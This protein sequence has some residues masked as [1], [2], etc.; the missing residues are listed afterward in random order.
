MLLSGQGLL[1]GIVDYEVQEKVVSAQSTADFSA[2]LEMN[3]Q[4]FVHELFEFWLRSL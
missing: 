2:A 4:V 3:E 1:E